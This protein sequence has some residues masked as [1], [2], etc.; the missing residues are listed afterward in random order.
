VIS[1]WECPHGRQRSRR[2]ERIPKAMLLWARLPRFAL[3]PGGI[4]NT[5]RRSE[6]LRL[7]AKARRACP[8]IERMTWLLIILLLRC[9]ANS[10]SH[11]RPRAAGIEETAGSCIRQGDGTWSSIGARSDAEGCRGCD[12]QGQRVRTAH[13]VSGCIWIAHTRE[14]VPRQKP[15]PRIC[16]RPADSL[17]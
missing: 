2:R 17:G 13:G 5:C 10:V 16:I 3:E 11:N 14:C 7:W 4:P 9:S 15:R 6:L 8:G 12:A 1:L